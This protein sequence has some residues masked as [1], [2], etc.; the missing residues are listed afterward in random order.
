MKTIE[1][2]WTETLELLQKKMSRSSFET[3][4]KGL[5]IQKFDT[6]KRTVT[7]NAENEFT[8]QW[9]ETRLKHILEDAIHEVTGEPYAISFAVRVKTFMRYSMEQVP[10][11]VDP[12]EEHARQNSDM[13]QQILKEL[14]SLHQRFDRMETELTDIRKEIKAANKPTK[15]PRPLQ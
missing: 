13:L 1:E 15:I 3:W 11:R 14:Q 2:I 8:R 6:K 4:I 7:I 5:S 9:L 10:T 12:H